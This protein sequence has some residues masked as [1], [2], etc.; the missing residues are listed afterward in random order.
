MKF[1]EG[2]GNIDIKTEIPEETIEMIEQEVMKIEPEIDNTE[3]KRGL[4]FR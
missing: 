4:N 3:H 2:G 1:H